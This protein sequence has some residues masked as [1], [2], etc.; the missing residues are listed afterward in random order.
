MQFWRLYR[1]CVVEGVATEIAGENESKGWERNERWNELNINFVRFRWWQSIITL[2]RWKGQD[3]KGFNSSCSGGGGGGVL[4]HLS[5]TL[6]A[7]RA[8]RRCCSNDPGSSASTPC[9]FLYRHYDGVLPEHRNVK[10][11]DI[12][13]HNLREEG[14]AVWTNVV[15]V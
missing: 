3:G 8:A 2:R 14:G 9:L 1:C 11:N 7:G 13:V 6:A 10:S 12:Q 15:Q 5:T 4:D